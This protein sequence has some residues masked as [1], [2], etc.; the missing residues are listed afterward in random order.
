LLLGGIFIIDSN[1]FHF[2]DDMILNILLLGVYYVL[3]VVV[4]PLL[5]LPPVDPNSDF[6]ASVSSILAFLAN[7]NQI[8]PLTTV[9]AILALILAVEVGV[10]VYKV[11]MWVVRRIPTQS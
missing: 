3:L 8:F 7:I 5:L 9:F 4:S 10:M 2:T 6:V 11:I 1:I